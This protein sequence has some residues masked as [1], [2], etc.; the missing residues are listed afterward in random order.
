MPPHKNPKLNFPEL[1]LALIQI[2]R[3][4]SDE[5]RRE[6]SG[7][8]SM[9]AEYTKDVVDFPGQ[10]KRGGRGQELRECLEGAGCLSS[11]SLVLWIIRLA[12]WGPQGRHAANH[13]LNSIGSFAEFTWSACQFQAYSLCTNRHYCR[14]YHVCMSAWIACK[15]YSGALTMLTD[16]IS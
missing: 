12:V 10:F 14:V 2:A 1:L 16:A 8:L 7:L 13:P 9:I 4:C 15:L 11:K 6:Q 5:R 3:H